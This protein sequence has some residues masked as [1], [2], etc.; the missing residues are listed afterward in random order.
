M[1]NAPTDIDHDDIVA[2]AAFIRSR[3]T[4]VLW[5][6]IS[7]EVPADTLLKAMAFAEWRKRHFS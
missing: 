2:A 6:I 5:A 4:E 3:D 1:N 7:D